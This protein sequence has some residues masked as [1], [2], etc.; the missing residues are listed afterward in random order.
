[1]ENA[2]TILRHLHLK[3]QLKFRIRGDIPA[4]NKK[5]T[6]LCR[7]VAYQSDSLTA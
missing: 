4:P 3:Q 6:A 2:A 7:T 1:M 5:A